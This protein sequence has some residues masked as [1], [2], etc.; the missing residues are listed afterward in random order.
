M[1]SLKRL[2]RSEAVE[3]FERLERTDLHDERSASFDELRTS[4]NRAA[5]GEPVEPLNVWNDW[6]WLLTKIDRAI[7]TVFYRLIN[8]RPRVRFGAGGVN[9]FQLLAE[10]AVASK[11]WR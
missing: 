3:R 5:H 6:N 8:G 4:E 7:Y 10:V 9:A 11:C 1:V 2:E